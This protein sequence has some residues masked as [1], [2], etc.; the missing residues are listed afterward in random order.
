MQSLNKREPAALNRT[1]SRPIK[2]NFMQ[3]LTGKALDVRI[4]DSMM[5][6]TY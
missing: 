6:I 2:T 5:V 4:G 3:R 1:V